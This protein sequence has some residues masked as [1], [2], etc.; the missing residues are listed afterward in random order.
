MNSLLRFKLEVPNIKYSLSLLLFVFLIL[1]LGGCWS[2]RELNELAIV[3]A[4]GVDR[5]NEQYE[6]SVQIVNPGQIASKKATSQ[7][8][9]ITYHA[10]GKSLFEAIRKLTTLTPRKPYYSHAQ[11]IIIGEELAEEGMNNILDLFQRDPEGRSEFNILIARD[12][13]AKEV[14]SI[15][16]PLEDIPAKNILNALKSS[17]QAIGTTDS[18]ILDDLINS[19]S[20]KGNSA[21]LSTIELHGDSAIGNNQTNVERIQNPAILKFGDFALFK[22]YKL[23]GFL[24]MAESKSY[25]YMNNHIKSTFEI[26]SCPEK[27]KLTTEVTNSEAKITGRVQHGHPK[28]N[29][30]L[31][32]EQNVADVNCTID[33]TKPQ[34]I[35]AL[36]KA[37]S[38]AIKKGL[39]QTLDT[40][41]KT[42]KVDALQFAE[43]LYRQDY[44]G[45][46]KIK[47]NWATLFPEID[48]KVQVT[49]NTQGIGTSLNKDLQ[50]SY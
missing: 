28:I 20:G 17:E 5:V 46:N 32:V 50:K 6:I 13:T 23:V 4:V 1:L 47:D 48:V 25:N 36:N 29:I 11:I 24:T 14:L 18:V 16:T 40:L 22:D 21:V 27:G 30:K 7:S 35:T 49:V 38:E 31:K 42:Y 9:V 8:P 33:L 3:A 10:T 45:W 43:I 12:T 19:L 39:E 37:T 44:K 41:Q 26:L 15:L 34:N 2:K